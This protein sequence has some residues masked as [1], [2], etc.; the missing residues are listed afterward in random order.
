MDGR[1]EDRIQAPC[2]GAR[3]EEPRALRE[4]LSGDHRGPGLEARQLARG[5]VLG[6]R[7]WLHQ[8]P[9]TG[10]RRALGHLE[11]DGRQPAHRRRHGHLQ[12]VPPGARTEPRVEVGGPRRRQGQRRIAH[13]AR[14]PPR[15]PTGGEEGP[16]LGEEGETEG[17][18][19]RCAQGP[20]GLGFCEESEPPE[21]DAEGPRVGLERHPWPHPRPR[22]RHP[23]HLAD[24]DLSG[25]R[26]TLQPVLARP[27]AAGS[28][29]V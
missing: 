19:G 29:V 10:P 13:H 3:L 27:V 28:G 6:L 21:R 11:G 4:V 26:A 8:G 24:E 22:R 16:R 12:V 23:H 5:L 25:G 14:A 17:Q 7:A 9:R 20:P 18:G 1:D 15:R 2:E